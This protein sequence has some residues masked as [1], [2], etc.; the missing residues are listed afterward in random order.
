MTLGRSARAAAT[1]GTA[2]AAAMLVPWPARAQ[3]PDSGTVRGTVQVA[4]TGER[5]AGVAVALVGTRRGAVT[6]DSGVFVLA[7]VP[8]G[9]ATLRV[10]QLGY[11]PR[12]E[13]VEVPA[14]GEAVVTF[15]L[16]EAAQTLAT[17]RTEG[18]ATERE[19][20]ERTADVGRVKIAG[21]ML[22]RLPSIG[23]PDVLR[24][25]QLLPGV[26]A[27]ND[28]TAGYNVRGGESDQNLVLLDGIPVYNP[29]HL[30]GL[31]GTFLD[32][33]VGDVNLLTGGFPAPYGTRLSSVLDVTSENEMRPGVHGSAGVSMLASTLA[34]DGRL[35]RQRTSWS[36]GVRRTYADAVVGA[37]SDRVLPYHFQDAQL[38]TMTD[39]PGGATLGI[40][41][42]AGSDVMDADLAQFGDSTRPGGGRFLFQWGNRLAGATLRIPLALGDS[43]EYV[44]RLSLTLFDTE[45]DIAQ[46]ALRFD[47]AVS[48]TNASGTL[49]V[50]RG[51][52]TPSAGFELARHRVRY[53]AES[54]QTATV[55]FGLAQNPSA[56][57]LFA[58]DIWKVSER[59][60]L[61][62]GVRAEHVTGTGWYGLSPRASA[63][64]FV[65]RDLAVTVAA[66]Q[67]TQWIHAIRNED[68][69]LRIFDFWVASDPW[70]DVSTA[71]HFVLGGERWLGD[72]RFVRLEAWGKRYSD[73]PEPNHR[74]DPSVRGDE[75]RLVEGY[76]Y[77][78]DLLLRQLELGPVSG[79]LAYG[80][81]MS[82]RGREG[83]VYFPA[84]D[85][86][87]NLNLVA[88][89]RPGRRYEVSGRFGFGTGTPYTPIVGQ[90]VRRTYNAVTNQWDGTSITGQPDAIG[91]AR[92]SARF[93]S[94][95]RLD[96]SV[97]RPYRRGRTTWSPYL[98]I[99]NVYN[100]KNV[101]T[102]LFDYESNPPSRSAISQFPFVPSIGLA[103]E[104]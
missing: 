46:G 104:F 24:T 88:A 71:R 51:R 78:A 103:V 14:G 101:F 41:A 66:G 70:I 65:S 22:G 95:Q 82:R 92:N 31:F 16:V 72:A 52:H 37:L 93:P 85:R 84:Q 5:L 75:F 45:L 99:V 81:S 28:F 36:A 76:S 77:G 40:T 7:G 19:S 50:H 69:P 2:L 29:F 62:G 97:A 34:L 68:I 39:L 44:Q 86:R 26:L 3:R 13:R 57:S 53:T 55:L 79:W 100:R 64:Y 98:Q 9:A 67:Y 59:L 60:L 6:S 48:E 32:E 89:W 56:M 49:V 83:D 18:V 87:H 74:D 54:P 17:V 11:Q 102:Y 10:R 1:I 33:T 4:A 80:Y 94:F 21:P 35:T 8:A 61:R 47:N 63:K 25:V 42:Y 91:G 96:L 23:E 38:H 15:A 90:L 20:F 27:R 12:D 73:I 43:A 58:D 30:A